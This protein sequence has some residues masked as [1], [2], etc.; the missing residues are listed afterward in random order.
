MQNNTNT[1]ITFTKFDNVNLLSVYKS[2]ATCC[3]HDNDFEKAIG[4]LKNAVSIAP[5]EIATHL[6]LSK[7]Y[8]SNNMINDA[9]SEL[10]FAL[11][12]DPFA[13]KLYFELSKLYAK[14]KDFENVA[15]ALKDAIKRNP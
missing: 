3:M 11:T 8:K 10:K 15:Q 1:S 12:L 2:I 6:A 5:K 7:A 13:D 4:Y 14:E 9:I